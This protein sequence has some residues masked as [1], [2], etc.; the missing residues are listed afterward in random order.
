VHEARGRGIDAR[1]L[2]MD[3]AD[4]ESVKRGVGRLVTAGTTSIDV[5]M[6]TLVARMAS[7]SM[8]NIRTSHYSRF[9]I[10]NFFVF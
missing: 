10:R 3:L 7:S 6:L 5:P 9:L 2:E 1:F 4:F 8:T